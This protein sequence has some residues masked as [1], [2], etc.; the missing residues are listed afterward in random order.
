MNSKTLHLLLA[1]AVLL[2]GG[3]LHSPVQEA[4][5]QRELQELRQQGVSVR[6]LDNA[7]VEVSDPVSGLKRVKTVQEPSE[8]EIRAWADTHGVPILEIDPTMV[9]TTR[10]AGWYHYWGQVPLSNG[11]E[12]PLVVA[13]VNRNALAEFYGSY[14]DSGQFDF[15][16]RMYEVDTNLVIAFSFTYTP[17]P[18]G[19]PRPGPSR[20]QTDVDYDSLLEVTFLYSGVESNYEQET[21]TGLPLTLNFAHQR[22][23]IQDPGFSG[24]YVGSL[25]GDTLTDFLY[26]GSEPDSS[27]FGRTKVYVAEYNPDS[28]N[29]VRV[30]ST[31]YDFGSV[32]ALGG[33][34]VGDFDGDGRA[35]FVA[36]GISGGVYLVENQS[37]NTYLYSWQDSTAFR[38]MY[39]HAAGDVD[40]D[41]K[42]EFFVGATMSNGSWTVVYEADS[43]DHYSPTFVLHLLS[44]G[45]L[46]EPTYFTR[47]IDRDGRL[48]LVITSGR[49]LYIFKANGNDSYYLWYLKREDQI[50]S[51]QFYDINR[52]GLNDLIISKGS[53]SLYADIYKADRL[54]GLV[55]NVATTR[56]V[57]IKLEQSFPNPFNP[58]MR[59][60]YSLPPGMHVQLAIYDLAGRC[61]RTFEDAKQP[62]GEHEVVWNGKNDLGNDVASGVYFYQL[63]TAQGRLTRKALLI[64]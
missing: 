56:P 8:V 55:D 32:S 20:L 51:V 63:R 47:D 13:D 29:F 31:D 1:F 40:R 5:L 6:F 48:E 12:L 18:V 22:Y 57:G 36:S 58:A 52:D 3:E 38:N 16:T 43:N 17:L 53:A 41:G 33:F 34:G 42:I 24:I 15:Q 11:K 35:E 61:I 23:Q 7:A 4:S 45:S 54:T 14:R 19:Q 30:W 62:D 39:Y 25:D 59:I 26:K 44:G 49:Y 2:L 9:D 60:R 50:G 10:F 64:R 28:N 27:M 37:D 46:D 21:A